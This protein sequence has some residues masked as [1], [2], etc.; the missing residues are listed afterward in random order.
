M[1]LSEELEVTSS[2]HWTGTSTEPGLM[3]WTDNIYF[4]NIQKHCI[5]SYKMKFSPFL[6]KIN[7]YQIFFG[8]DW[9][10]QVASTHGWDW[11]HL[12]FYVQKELH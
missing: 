11:Q 9:H 5:N 3:V 4:L 8:L 6:M 10:H 12:F 2:W 1:D 7:Q